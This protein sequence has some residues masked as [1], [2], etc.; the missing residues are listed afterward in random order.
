MITLNFEKKNTTSL[1]SVGRALSHGI[2]QDGFGL[3]FTIYFRS[4]EITFE[5]WPTLKPKLFDCRGVDHHTSI[6]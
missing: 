2:A 3:V 5:K 4:R 6:V 1:R